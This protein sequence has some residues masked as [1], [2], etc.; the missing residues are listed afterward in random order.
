MNSDHAWRRAFHNLPSRAPLSSL[1]IRGFRNSGFSEMDPIFTSSVKDEFRWL[2]DPEFR[3][4]I[5]LNGI[6]LRTR[7]P[8]V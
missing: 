2:T 5:R 4:C 7:S 1:A 6:E 8:F 3:E